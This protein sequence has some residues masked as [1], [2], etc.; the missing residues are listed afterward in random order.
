M[1][2]YKKYEVWK[3]SHKLALEVYNQTKSFPKEEM[4]AIT[5]QLRRASLSIPTNIV[6]GTSR[7]SEKEFAYFINIASGS[8]AEVE[9]LLEFSKSLKYLSEEQHIMLH[10][11]VLAIRKMLNV[12][13]KKLKN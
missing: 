1:R 9:Y 5:S 2:D 3:K 7:N 11:E 8:S 10:K 4:Y 13:Y 12:L 6:E